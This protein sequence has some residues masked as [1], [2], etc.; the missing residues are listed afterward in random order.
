LDDGNAQIKKSGGLPAEEGSSKSGGWHMGRQSS[1]FH[2][3]RLEAENWL[4]LVYHPAGAVWHL[5]LW[6]P[7]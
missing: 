7:Q 2:M 4:I 1:P 5:R 3:R 6:K